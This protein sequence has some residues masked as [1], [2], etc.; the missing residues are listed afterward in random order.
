[1]AHNRA[2]S[3][4]LSPYLKLEWSDNRRICIYRMYSTCRDTVDY[5]IQSLVG[6]MLDWPQDQPYLA[7]CDFSA[8]N[9]HVTPYLRSQSEAVFHVASR[10]HGRY[11]ILLSETPAHLVFSYFMDRMVRHR[12]PNLEMQ[13]FYDQNMALDWL[14]QALN[15]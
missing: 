7:L 4:R 9:V 6:G 8:P 5:L 11:A 1:M 15:D 2:D 3:R 12:M 13:H 14:R 10:L